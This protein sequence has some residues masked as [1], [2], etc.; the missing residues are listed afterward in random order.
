MKVMVISLILLLLPSVNA[1]DFDF[2]F[3]DNIN[4]NESFSVSISLKST[5]MYDVKIFT[6]NSSDNKIL[7]SEV[8]SE[9]LGD[10]WQDSWLYLISSFPERKDYEM[11]VIGDKSSRE[12][13]VQL[14]KNG[15]TTYTRECKPLQYALTTGEISK[16]TMPEEPQKTISNDNQSNNVIILNSPVKEFSTKQNTLKTSIICS[17]FIS[18]ILILLLLV[19][20]PRI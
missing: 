13:C 3:K 9:V 12:L 18:S 16:E 7:R 2:S 14:R 6:H 15:K 4:I 11:R 20:K 5:E 1:L 8:T 19:I 17:S 10:K